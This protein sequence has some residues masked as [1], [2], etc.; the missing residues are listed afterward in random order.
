[1]FIWAPENSD[2]KQQGP[3]LVAVG[4][5]GACARI[6]KPLPKRGARRRIGTAGLGGGGGGAGLS[7]VN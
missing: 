4:P 2:P 3:S 5:T 7:L 1:M 6:W